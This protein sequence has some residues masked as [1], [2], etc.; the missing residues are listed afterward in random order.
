MKRLTLGAAALCVA[1]GCSK[2][3][4]PSA[5]SA[6]P[7]PAAP[8]AAEPAPVAEV[9]AAAPAPAAT[10]NTNEGAG[11]V[12]DHT[13]QTLQGETVKLDS[14]RGKV[15]LIV[16]TASECGYT[17]QYEGLEKIYGKY[18]DRGLV[19]VGFPSNDFGGQEPGSAEE[20]ATF[21]KKN[22]GVTFPMMAKVHAKGSEI[23]PIYKT[24]TQDTGDGIKGEVKWNFT[25]FLVDKDG[26]VVARFEPNVKPESAELTGAIEKLLPR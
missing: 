25:K 19:V 21:C 3:S 1:V 24:L 20:I 6:E 8:K 23:A 4:T 15:L 22:Y 11:A 10:A 7:A 9:A 16:N 17:P 26:K 18:K 14:Y 5:A 12:I 13:V 2:Q